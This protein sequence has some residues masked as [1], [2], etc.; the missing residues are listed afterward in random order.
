MDIG[1]VS[2]INIIDNSAIQKYEFYFANG[3]KNILLSDTENT[4]SLI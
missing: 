1:D 4:D 2:W 3:K